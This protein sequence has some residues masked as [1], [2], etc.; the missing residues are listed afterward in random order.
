M[1]LILETIRG[2]INLVREF[3]SKDIYQ[4]IILMVISYILL[5]LNNKMLDYTEYLNKIEQNHELSIK[6]REY[7]NP[8]ISNYLLKLI[9]GTGCDYAIEA[10][11]HN[12]DKSL[13]GLSFKK[14]TMLYEEPKNQKD[15]LLAK[16]YQHQLNSLYK[17]TSYL[18]QR[19]YL[20]MSIDELRTIDKRLANELD[21]YD[22]KQVLIYNFYVNGTPTG[23]LMLLYKNYDKKKE[24]DIMSN[25]YKYS[26]DIAR[27]LSE[28]Y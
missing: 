13:N 14:F 7:V 3:K 6:Q 24:I 25:A 23:F 18:Y 27:L 28:P 15:I 26:M 20:N 12:G 16:E 11:Y 1:K 8:R 19:G 4:A 17:F 9:N 22:I 2:Y 21:L 10:E 5:S